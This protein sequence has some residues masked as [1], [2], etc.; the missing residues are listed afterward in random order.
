MRKP[1]TAH[2]RDKLRFLKLTVDGTSCICTPSEA[3]DMMDSPDEYT[4]TEV[5]MTQAQYDALPEFQGW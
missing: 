1:L 3:G 2:Q 4:V 5:W